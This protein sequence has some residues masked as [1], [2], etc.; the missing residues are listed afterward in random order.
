MATVRHVFVAMAWLLAAGGFVA[1]RVNNARAPVFH[2][3][4]AF[5]LLMAAGT[6]VFPS[7]LSTLGPI[8][9][10]GS[11]VLFVVV[12]TTLM[13]LGAVRKARRLHVG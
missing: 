2:G 7:L 3:V 12:L 10:A 4:G 5:L 11:Y 13:T 1:L 8:V 9:W 6:A